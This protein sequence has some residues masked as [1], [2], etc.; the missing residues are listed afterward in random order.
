MART[1]AKADIGPGYARPPVSFANVRAW[2]QLGYR[3][4]TALPPGRDLVLR[5]ESRVRRASS[6]FGLRSMARR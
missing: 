5:D 3:S 4:V 1:K 6:P 2:R